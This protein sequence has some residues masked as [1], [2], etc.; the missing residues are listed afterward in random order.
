M[1]PPNSL[2]VFAFAAAALSVGGLAQAATGDV[3]LR[4][5]LRPPEGASTAPGADDAAHWPEVT[6]LKP[7]HGDEE[8][9]E[10]ALATFCTQ[11]Y[12]QSLQI[13]FGVH[14]GDDPAVAVY[15]RIRARFPDLDMTLVIDP[16]PHGPN[17]K[18]D[19]LINML[20]FA[21]H[22]LLVISDADIHAP[23]G[24][25]R[26]VVTPLLEPTVGLS[27]TL[28]AGRPASGSVARQLGAA[29]INQAFLPGAL[30]GR[31]LGR[32]DCLGAVMAISAGTLKAVGGFAALSPHLADDAVLG[33]KVRALG[34][35]VALARSVPATSVVEGSFGELYTHE[36]RWGR[37]VRGQA[38]IGYPMS[39]IQA[40][41]AWAMIAACATG[42]A[43]W[44]LA[45]GGV[46]WGVRALIG[47]DMERLLCGR[48]EAPFWL[49]PIRDVLSLAIIVASHA[50]GRVAWRG[51]TLHI[52]ARKNLRAARPAP[53][54]PPVA[55]GGLRT[56]P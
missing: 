22:Q 23:P 51:Q 7:L 17:R 13:V 31:A 48:R 45:L 41:I 1:N 15:E 12:P 26:A 54:R 27:T 43:P 39:M 55:I 9:L 50:G 33:R 30:I 24:L 49:A 21:K 34:L 3:L 40:P 46:A 14:R 8:L 28:Y 2:E 47:A 25:V 37:T 38:P 16:T 29:Q 20:P 6:L 53:E 35:R 42:G 32:E 4:R 18:V 10:D 19:N 11:D 5:F 56:R 52:S 36:L 44:A